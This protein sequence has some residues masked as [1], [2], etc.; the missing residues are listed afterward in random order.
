MMFITRKCLSRRTF[1]RGA[2]AAVAL[3]FLDAMHPALSAE[4]ST[5]AAPVHRL[6]IA[7]YPHGVVDDTWNPIGEGFDYKISD[8]LSPLERHRRKF[9]VLRGLTS[10]PDRGKTDFHDRAITSFLTGCERNVD[11]VHVGVSMD[12]IAARQLGKGTRFASL[13]L[14]TQAPGELGGPCY[15]DA[16]TLLPMEFNPRLVFERLCGDGDKVDPA[17]QAARTADDVSILDAIG[18]RIKSLNRELGAPDQRK[19]DQYL[20]SIRDVER[21]VRIAADTPAVN[22]PDMQRP[23]GVPDSW[24][25]HVKLMF[26]LQA[27]ALQADLSRVIT[28]QMAMEASVIT[29]PELGI[30]MSFH[31]ISHHNFEKQKLDNLSKINK[32]HSELF[33]YYLDKLDAIKEPNGSVLDNTLVMYGSDLSNPTVHS[34]RNLPIVVAGGGALGVKGGRYTH[35]TGNGDGPPLTNLYLELLHRIGVPIDKI[36]D[37]TGTLNLLGA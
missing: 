16:N 6:S 23:A 8:G 12:Q 22:L 31:E 5:A 1:L 27:L 11:K 18:G 26:D 25:D 4:R 9:T 3:P 28:F 32:H 10:A 19:L 35:V 15:W 7:L 36:G 34:Q 17:A 2:G 14:C 21:R 24:P 20:E 13:E 29:F 37:S 30:A 33:A